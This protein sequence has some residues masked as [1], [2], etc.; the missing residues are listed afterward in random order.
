M[1]SGELLFLIAL[2][3]CFLIGGF[4]GLALSSAAMDTVYHDSYFVVGHFHLVLSIAALFGVV[5][6]IR[7]FVLLSWGGALGEVESRHGIVV[8]TTS[9]LW[10]FG[11]QHVVGIDGHPRRIFSSGECEMGLIE[12]SNVCIPILLWAPTILMTEIGTYNSFNRSIWV[13]GYYEH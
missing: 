4:T 13:R 5:I 12:A 2:Q 3:V 10:L 8:V 6:A 7:I 1:V 9:V 11:L